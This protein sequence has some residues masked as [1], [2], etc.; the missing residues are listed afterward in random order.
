MNILVDIIVRSILKYKSTGGILLI[1]LIVSSSCT[2]Y[3][4]LKPGAYERNI[5]VDAEIN[6]Y[7]QQHAVRLSLTRTVSDKVDPPV[8]D[9]D[10]SVSFGDSTI[11]FNE[12]DT[13]PGLYLSEI[14]FGAIYDKVYKLHVNCDVDGD[15]VMENYTSEATMPAVLPFDSITY[16]YIEQ[17]KAVSLNCWAWDPPETN[18]YCFRAW[19]NDTLVSDTIYELNTVDD[20]FFN[21][22]YTN[23]IPCA[24]LQ[25]EKPDELV[26]AGDKVTL[27]IMNI[28]EAYFNYINTA[29]DE[30][31]GYN[32][33]FGGLPAN[34]EGNISNNA[35]GVFRVYSSSKA[36]TVIEEKIDRGTP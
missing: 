7:Y 3:I 2:E 15:G 22:N 23:G 35:L 19:V 32:P 21:G 28:D 26:N 10:V 24:Y 25:D 13:I 6:N 29:I 5:C 18:Y 36:S 12:V 11:Y 31:F 8:S 20:L 34:V 14:P 33:M 4:D 16:D 9:A 27:E 30:Y 1:F 17:W